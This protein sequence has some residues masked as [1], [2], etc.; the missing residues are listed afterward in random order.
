MI[1]FCCASEDPIWYFSCAEYDVCDHG[2]VFLTFQNSKLVVRGIIIVKG[3]ISVW[4]GN[5]YLAL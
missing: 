5:T 3:A 2:C 1:L 4:G